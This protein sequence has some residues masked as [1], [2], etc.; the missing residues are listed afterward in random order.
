M[1]IGG[2]A[3]CKTTVKLLKNTLQAVCHGFAM[4]VFGCEINFAIETSK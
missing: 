1:K 4:Y 3:Y 2:S